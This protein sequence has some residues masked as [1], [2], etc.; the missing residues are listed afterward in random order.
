MPESMERS[1]SE[2]AGIRSFT[3]ARRTGRPGLATR[4]PRIRSP[5]SI[6]V[7]CGFTMS[8]EIS[9][10]SVHNCCAARPLWT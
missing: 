6:P 10:S 3:A 1:D 8:R 9:R 2:D 7:P 5:T 4:T